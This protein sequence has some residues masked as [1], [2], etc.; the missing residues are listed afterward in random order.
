MEVRTI[1]KETVR[2]CLPYGLLRLYRS[3]K[4]AK[5]RRL[6][7]DAPCLLPV[8]SLD[9]LW[10]DIGRVEVAVPGSQVFNDDTMV[11]PLRELLTLGAICQQIQPKRIF[12]IGTFTGI[13]A[14]MM[15][16]N[17][18]EQTQLYTLDLDPSILPVHQHG[19]GV[20][21]QDY[22]AGEEFKQTNYAHKIEQLYGDSR[23]FDYTPYYGEM[24]LVF[25][26]GDHTLEFVSSDTAQAFKLVR[27]GGVIIWDDYRWTAAH[28]ECADVSRCVDT[29]RESGRC[30]SIA[31][32]RLA[33]YINR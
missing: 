10:P 27:P 3:R 8:R 16:T 7:L 2:F 24:D 30:F 9:Q 26:D 13:S 29:L 23:F 4:T 21:L 17:S 33:V 5:Q 14:L 19:L 11:L 25:V 20:G 22:T 12:E 1:A 15:A 28:P 31:G 6:L 32:T 18:P